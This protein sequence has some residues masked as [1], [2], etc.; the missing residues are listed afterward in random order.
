[1]TPEV[2]GSI[3]GSLEGAPTSLT[4]RMVHALSI[5]GVRLPELGLVEGSVPQG[6]LREFA[7][8][9]CAHAIVSCL[10]IEFSRDVSAVASAVSERSEGPS[11]PTHEAST[12]QLRER[13]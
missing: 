3:S 7:A 4:A 9:L 2:R 6:V 13:E 8:K 5:L 12:S 1:M 10:V 11:A